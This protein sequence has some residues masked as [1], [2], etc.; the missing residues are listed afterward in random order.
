MVADIG[1]QVKA[2]GWPPSRG[3]RA[4][5]RRRL[6]RRPGGWPAALPD[7]CP[8]YRSGTLGGPGWKKSGESYRAPDALF[9]IAFSLRWYFQIITVLEA[10]PAPSERPRHRASARL[11]RRGRRVPATQLRSDGNASAHARA[12]P[13]LPRPA[14]GRR[15]PGRSRVDFR[16]SAY[17]PSA[18]PPSAPPA[19]AS[20]AS[21]RFTALALPRL[22]S[23]RS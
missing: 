22:S 19:L 18:C 15:G 21:R 20:S 14:P 4:R 10:P 17:L 2:A 6:D 16:P 11:F 13:P 3:L 9:W 12:L 5:P 23:C 7:A 1:D 8:G